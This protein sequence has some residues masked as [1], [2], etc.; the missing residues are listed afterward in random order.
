MPQICQKEG[1]GLASAEE[2]QADSKQCQPNLHISC[3]VCQGAPC[4]GQTLG[5][6]G[7]LQTSQHD[8]SAFHRQSVWKCK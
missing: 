8:G 4:M 6:S 5:R 3:M 7:T 1:T 2:H